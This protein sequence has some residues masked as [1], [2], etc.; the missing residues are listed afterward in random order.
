MQ[1]TL[2][3]D[4][5][6]LS[7]SQLVRQIK[8]VVEAD[9]ILND[10]WVRGEVSNFSQA[11]SRHVYFTLKD[12]DAQ[13]KCVMWRDDAARAFRLPANGEAIEAHGR[14]SIYETRGDVQLYVDEIKLAGAGAL[15]QEFEKLRARLDAEGLFDAARKRALPQF[16]KIIGVVTSRQGAVLRDMCRVLARRYP[17]AQVLLAP[18]LVQGAGA[19]EMIANQIQ[20]INEFDIDVLIVARGGGSIEDLWAFN[21]EIVARAIYASRVPVISAVGHET[22]FT[23]ADFVADV[24]APTPSVA[25]ELVAPEARELRASVRA[26]RIRIA[27]IARERIGDAR[28]NLARQIYALR[29]NSPRARVENDRQRVDELSRRIAA[30]IASRLA[31]SIASSLELRREE[32]NGATRQLSALNPDATLARGY[33]IVREKKSGRVVKKKS[34]VAGRKEIRVRVS[35]GEFEAETRA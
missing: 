28:V 27:Q 10:V 3:S 11:A 14:V 21:A 29:R 13:I 25:A 26:A 30:S 6:A 34:Q 4:S 31:A 33:A 16:P 22:D 12:R 8:D 23:I 15:W 5:S 1:P 18:T 20:R 35:D 7:V 17:L 9:E 32:L 24:R 19:A 2:F